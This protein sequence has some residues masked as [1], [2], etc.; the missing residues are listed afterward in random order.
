[1]Q[2]PKHWQ[3]VNH[4]V[5]LVTE[6][7]RILEA[8]DPDM[9]GPILH[10]HWI[11]KKTLAGKVSNQRVDEIYEQARAAGATGGKLLGAGTGGFILFYC[12]EKDNARFCS[13]MEPLLPMPFLFENNGSELIHKEKEYL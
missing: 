6:L 3:T 4:I 13:A 8:D 12:P 5:W 2:S 11:L 7:K 9:L 10:E 1:M